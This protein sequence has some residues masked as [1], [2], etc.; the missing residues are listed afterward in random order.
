MGI[1][2]GIFLFVVGAVLA[3]ALQG[4]PVSFVDIHMVGLILMGAGVVIFIISLALTFRK[5]KTVT[6]TSTA[7]DPATGQRVER[8]EN[9][10]EMNS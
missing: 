7:V 1:G 5:A 10:S 9:T 3:F 6:T 4:N 8:H 2:S